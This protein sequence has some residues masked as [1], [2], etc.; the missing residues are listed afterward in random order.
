MIVILNLKLKIKD[1][2]GS[3]LSQ[4]LYPGRQSKVNFLAARTKK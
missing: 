3:D 1:S 2:T 4:G